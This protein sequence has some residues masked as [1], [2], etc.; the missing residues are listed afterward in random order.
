M[1]G[2]GWRGPNFMTTTLA[3]LL[4]VGLIA[5]AITQ[6]WVEIDQD[7]VHLTVTAPES[8]TFA[9]DAN[10]E[11]SLTYTANLK[12]NTD[13]LVLLEAS[14]PC[15]IHRWFVAD[16]GGNFV[17]GEP[18]E[19][20]A[21]VIMNADLAPDTVVEDTVTL[22]LDARRYTRGASY[23]IMVS[24]WGYERFHTFEMR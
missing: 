4:V 1:A 22:A 14:T 9:P 5:V 23:Q 15:R 20:C 24:S 2:G 13:D 8:V 10:G 3:M 21:Q 11:I 18:R 19:S 17:Q 16:A 6:G 7:P 12:N